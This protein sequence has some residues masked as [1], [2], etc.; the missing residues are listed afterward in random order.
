MSSLNEFNPAIVLVGLV[1]IESLYHFTPLISLINSNLCST[2][3]NSFI[4]FTIISVSTRDFVAPI[5]AA[6]FS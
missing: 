3:L 1:P 4:A 5:A 2:P 6:I